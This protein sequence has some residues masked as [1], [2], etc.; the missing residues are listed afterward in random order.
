MVPQNIFLRAISETGQH[1]GF[2]EEISRN[3]EVLSFQKM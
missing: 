3:L 1:L 2:L